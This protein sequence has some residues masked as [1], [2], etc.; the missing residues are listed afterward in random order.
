MNVYFTY[1]QNNPYIPKQRIQFSS[2]EKDRMFK[3]STFLNVNI[4]YF[5]RM[6]HLNDFFQ[7]NHYRLR[8]YIPVDISYQELNELLRNDTILRGY[9]SNSTTSFSIHAAYNYNLFSRNYFSLIKEYLIKNLLLFNHMGINDILICN[10]LRFY[11]YFD[12]LRVLEHLLSDIPN[13]NKMFCIEN[14]EFFS[15]A[16]KCLSFSNTLG[17]PFI[18]DNLH[19]KLN[20]NYDINGLA[21][22]ITNTWKSNDSHV[23]VH[24][25]NG[26]SFG[27]HSDTI[28]VGEIVQ[29]IEAFKPHTDKLTIVLELQNVKYALEIF[30]SNTKDMLNWSD[31]N[32]ITF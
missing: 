6:R 15:D 11:N 3:Y 17:I 20:G 23:F 16:L 25:S 22:K 5:R 13:L 4:A 30:K 2:E 32:H 9:F 1:V 14:C 21:E 28:I 27:R 29:L 7:C 26:D 31:W 18:F 12:S 24:Y 8:P 10:H 19:N